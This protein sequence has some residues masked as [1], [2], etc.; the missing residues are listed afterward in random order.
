M[1]TNDLIR[2]SERR[3]RMQLDAFFDAWLFQSG[4]PS[5]W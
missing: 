3:S 2:L 4:K 5:S 1:T